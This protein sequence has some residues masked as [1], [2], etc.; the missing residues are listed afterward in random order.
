MKQQNNLIG[1]FIEP[2][3]IMQVFYNICNFFTVLPNTK[4]YFFCGKNLKAYYDK[5]FVLYDNL[6]IQELPTNNLTS[7]QYSDLM[8][9]MSFWSQ[10]K[11]T[12]CLTI[13]TDGCL[14]I[15]SPYNIDYFFKYDYVGGYS[16]KH[17]R[18][19]M[20]SMIDYS[21]KFPCLNGGFSL[22]NISKCI[23]VI[24]KFPPLPCDVNNNEIF[25]T[26]AED[27]YFA[28]GMLKLGYNVGLDELAVNFCSH[29]EYNSSSFCIHKLH[30][31]VSSNDLLECNNTPNNQYKLFI[32]PLEEPCYNGDNLNPH[33]F[34][35]I[36]TY[37]RQNGT[38][39]SY[40]NRSIDSILKQQYKLWTLLIIGDKY[41]KP[42]ELFK[43]IKEKNR[44]TKNKI[45]FFNNV[46]VERDSIDKNIDKK[47]LWHCAG[48]NSGNMGLNFARG[49][50]FKYY[51]HIDDDDYWSSSHLKLIANIYKQD[52]NCIFVNTLSTHPIFNLIPDINSKE[53]YVK[54]SNIDYAHKITRISHSSISFRC[55][56]I[57]D[58][59]KTNLKKGIS[60]PADYLM[61][62]SIFEYL[63]TH[64]QYTGWCVNKLTCKHDEEALS[65]R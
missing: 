45:I 5:I 59:Y 43:L 62:T 23:N 9:S 21:V 10:F 32:K 24:K 41:E 7:S 53:L 22:R 63:K 60:K 35:I 29:T 46:L 57:V 2:R 33:F 37:Y 34:I 18:N 13:Q 50:N 47:K 3:K 36:C 12:Y 25:E 11:A 39:Y 64:T 51:A 27:M 38:S 65:I 16:K 58:N 61:I 6:I 26:Y 49:N 52:S 56:I 15:N 31:Y 48:V 54:W 8:K 4:L 44:L 17:W 14:C 42:D 40:L 20:G 28:Y 19:K 1:I 55:D 30:K